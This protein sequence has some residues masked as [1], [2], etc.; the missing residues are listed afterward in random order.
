MIVDADLAANSPS[1]YIKRYEDPASSEGKA[2]KRVWSDDQRLSAHSFL[3][4]YLLAS[5]AAGFLLTVHMMLTSTQVKGFDANVLAWLVIFV[6]YVYA[7]VCFS[8]LIGMFAAIPAIPLI[9]SLRSIGLTGPV[10]HALAGAGAAAAAVAEVDL[11]NSF[12]GNHIDWSTVVIGAVAGLVYW[13][14]FGRVR[15]ILASRKPLEHA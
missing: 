9:L 11:M 12:G 4:A 15:T 10:P 14:A 7:S 6:A 8:F 2:L 3:A 1:H 5:F 13:I